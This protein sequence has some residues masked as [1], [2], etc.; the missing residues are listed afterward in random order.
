MRVAVVVT[1]NYSA[2]NFRRSLLSAAVDSGLETYLVAPSG[3]HDGGFEDM[4]VKLA[5]VK[6]KRVI[7]PLVDAGYLLSLH[8]AF[9]DIKPDV[10]HNISIKPNIYGA[11][12]ARRAR[13][14]HVVGSV[15]GLGNIFMDE[16]GLRF[17]AMRP[18]VTRMY[19]SAFNVTDRIWFQNPDDAEY[20]LAAGMVKPEQVVVI[21]GSGVNLGD[22]TPDAVD[23]DAAVRI[24][25]GLGMMD[26]SITVCMI[27]RA[28]KSKGV[29]EFIKA[30]E[31]LA[32]KMPSIRFL[33][34]GGA[35]NGN[36]LS[37]PAD[38]LESR[39]SEN[40][41]WL[42]WRND[43]REILHISDIVVL[44]SRFRE[45]LPKSLLE[46]MA[47]G[48]PVVT[49]DVAGCREVVEE[50]GNGFLVKPRDAES[51]AARIGE[52]AADGAM[53]ERFG[54]RSLE[55]ARQ[56]FDA[57]IVNRRILEDLYLWKQAD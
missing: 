57:N 42:G 10:V 49:T 30:C 56:T 17:R 8:R 3:P 47:M 31:M 52:L 35:E 20:F 7:S 32:G 6:A 14:P 43:I 51:L 45:G 22:F 13:I 23:T 19:R 4:G 26:S 44:P 54:E 50:G 18:M 1:E 34:V 39:Q 28:L 27:A 38:Y 41:R 25:S 53:R 40:F 36:A 15:T 11:A 48:K 24:R 55:L 21:K 5:P 29:E 46:A 9:R 2:W 16:M 37:L 12:A 33:F